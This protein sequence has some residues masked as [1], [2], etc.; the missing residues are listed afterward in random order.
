MR[1][2]LQT[3]LVLVLVVSGSAWDAAEGP[4]SA[5]SCTDWSCG[6]RFAK[7]KDGT[8]YEAVLDEK[9]SRPFLYPLWTAKQTIK[10]ITYASVWKSFNIY[11]WNEIRTTMKETTKAERTGRT[12]PYRA[13][14]VCGT[15][16]EIYPAMV[17]HVCY[18]LE[19]RY[20]LWTVNQ[21]LESYFSWVEWKQ[22]ETP[23]KADDLLSQVGRVGGVTASTASSVGN[24]VASAGMLASA[25]KV[26]P[27]VLTSA[28]GEVGITG[29][30]AVT[31][32]AALSALS[33]GVA[34]FAGATKVYDALHPD[35]THRLDS[36]GWSLAGYVW[37]LP[38]PA[39]IIRCEDKDDYHLAAPPDHYLSDADWE[40]QN[41][42]Y[43]AATAKLEADIRQ[44][45]RVRARG[46]AMPGDWRYS[47]LTTESMK[48]QL[49]YRTQWQH[50]RAE[51]RKRRLA[52]M[53]WEI[54]AP[55]KLCDRPSDQPEKPI[56]EIL[57][58]P[59]NSLALTHIQDSNVLWSGLA[60]VKSFHV[61]TFT[62]VHSIYLCCA[63][64]D[65]KFS[66]VSGTPL[67]WSWGDRTPG[68]NIRFTFDDGTILDS[69]VI[70]GTR[71]PDVNFPIPPGA[72]KVTGIEV[73]FSWT[74][75]DATTITGSKPESLKWSVDV[76]LG[77]MGMSA[78]PQATNAGR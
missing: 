76:P 33:F 71:G 15:E 75:L 46:G 72:Q 2:R 49:Q 10:D 70:G 16:C 38:A 66:T 31:A 12:R 52:A 69:G 27:A 67:Q 74:T 29:G 73:A 36:E 14:N 9:S 48:R 22:L 54:C 63:T 5:Q 42:E 34:V 62:G 20:E 26:P 40:R 61:S 41:A 4:T 58:P 77:S 39:P 8:L 47:V 57:L 28:L 56:T 25:G 3:W 53:R 45:E 37:G 24:A 23:A 18:L 17:F 21:T 19:Q 59:P 13:G 32:S 68:V 7:R 35:Y 11:R 55:L 43:D 60:T 51:D 30:A 50:D 1:I 44:A 78:P 65:V 64:G 6:S